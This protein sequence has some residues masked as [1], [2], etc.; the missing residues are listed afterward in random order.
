MPV[1]RGRDNGTAIAKNLKYIN[2]SYDDDTNFDF[3]SGS[4]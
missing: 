4:D 2:Y 3:N 1:S